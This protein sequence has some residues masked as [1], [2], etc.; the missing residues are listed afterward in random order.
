MVILDNIVQKLGSGRRQPPVNTRM[1]LLPRDGLLV[2]KYFGVD[3][4]A[5]SRR[6]GPERATKA[7]KLWCT[8]ARGV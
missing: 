5:P 3:S 8:L 2:R 6:H 1:K 4:R 7:S